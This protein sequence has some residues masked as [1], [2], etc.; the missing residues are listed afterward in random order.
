MTEELINTCFLSAGDRKKA[1]VRE[2]LEIVP[3]ATKRNKCYDRMAGSDRCRIDK[4]ISCA[5][6][7][8]QFGFWNCLGQGN[9]VTHTVPLYILVYAYYRMIDFFVD[10]ENKKSG[11]LTS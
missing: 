6:H 1:R 2:V 7:A 11:V 3:E 9:N 5:W 8:A 4:E 10:K